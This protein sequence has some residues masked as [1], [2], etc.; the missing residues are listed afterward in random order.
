MHTLEL[1]Y[2]DGFFDRCTALSRRFPYALELSGNGY[3]HYP[4][5]PFPKRLFLGTRSLPSASA[6]TEGETCCGYFGYEWG[7]TAETGSSRPVFQGFPDGMFFLPDLEIGL[8]RE[9]ICLRSLNPEADLE[10][11]R[12]ET[13]LPE[14][15]Q[16]P[17]LIFTGASDRDGYIRRVEQIQQQIREGNLYEL[18]LCQYFEAPA[19]PD[20]LDL[21][22]CLNRHYP[23]PFSGWMKF[24]G[25]EIVCLSPERFLARRGERLFSQPIKG[26]GPRGKTPE[27]DDRNRRRLRESEKEQAENLMITDLVRNDLARVAIT[28]TTG[29]SELFG[30][31]AFPGVFQII[32]T[33]EAR[34]NPGTSETAVFQSAFPMGSMTGAPK[35]EVMQQ[36][37]TLES[38]RRGAYSG[39]MGYFDA[40]G[41]FDFNV[42][43]RSLFINHNAG[44]CGFAVGSAITIDSDPEEEWEECR[45][46]ARFIES[47][48]TIIW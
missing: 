7:Q 19:V 43:I 14:P 27:E 24:P 10:R 38:H 26:T 33:V 29:V 8:R 15:A 41:D 34:I 48:G 30:I 40:G 28:G 23:M 45:V 4:E 12:S 35:K 31:Y 11:I 37:R 42:L 17:E 36:I 9:T 20:G 21:Y 46:K 2:E 44:T 13:P 3:D 16:L 18:N 1:P 6:R 32:S 5:G 22:R 39:S 25:F 47:A